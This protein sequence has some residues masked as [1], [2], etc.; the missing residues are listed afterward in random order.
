MSNTPHQL[1]EDFPAF[2][3]AIHALKVR[4]AHFAKLSEQYQDINGQ[5]HRAETN[6][7]PMEDLA[8]ID[9]RKRR[10][11]LKDQIFAALK[12]AQPTS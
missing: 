11:A 12:V 2:A 6:V 9:I 10:A 1:H 5:I 3:E 8:M 4:D 7:E